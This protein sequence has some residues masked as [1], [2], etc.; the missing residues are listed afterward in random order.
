MENG[1]FNFPP[2]KLDY[3]S[4]GRG[5]WKYLALGT[6]KSKDEE[7]ETFKYK[8]SF[9]K[10]DW[11]LFHDALLAHRFNLLHDILPRFGI[12]AA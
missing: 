5:S 12:C 7:D 8:E 1:Y 4:K 3:R 10:S 11:K 6:V 2:V 9:L